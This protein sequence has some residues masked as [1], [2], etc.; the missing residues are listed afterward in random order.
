MR[1]TI[2]IFIIAALVLPLANIINAFSK[3]NS[4]CTIYGTI[5]KINVGNILLNTSY[6]TSKIYIGKYNFIY[7]LY[8]K[9]SNYID[10]INLRY[11]SNASNIEEVHL[12]KFNWKRLKYRCKYVSRGISNH[13]ECRYLIYCTV[14]FKNIRGNL[15]NN[16][17]FSKHFLNILVKACRKNFF[18]LCYCN[19]T[20]VLKLVECPSIKSLPL[21]GLKCCYTNQYSYYGP[22]ENISGDIFFCFTMYKKHSFEKVSL[23]RFCKLFINHKMYLVY[24]KYF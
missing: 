11:T 18:H 21:L 20:K 13:R 12:T 14:K 16:S 6:N 15:L 9:N 24:N 23:K 22:I 19:S 2:I 3:N 4:N 5:N 1:Y 8:L 7:F 10:K 17:I